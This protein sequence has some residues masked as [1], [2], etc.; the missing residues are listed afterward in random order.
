[1]MI[2]WNKHEKRRIIHIH[3][4]YLMLWCAKMINFEDFIEL[5][6]QMTWAPF[7][8]QLNTF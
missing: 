7:M 2:K 5:E 3:D 6:Y 4:E 1:M 8:V